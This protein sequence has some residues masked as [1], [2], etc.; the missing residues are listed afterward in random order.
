MTPAP[1]THALDAYLEELVRAL[2]AAVSRAQPHLLDD[3]HLVDQAIRDCRE[4]LDVVLEG[5]VS[6]WLGGSPDAPR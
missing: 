4:I 6:G 2:H 5:D 3:P 1:N